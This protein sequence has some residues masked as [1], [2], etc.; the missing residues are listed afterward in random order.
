MAGTPLLLWSPPKAGQKNLGLNPLGT[1]GTEAKF[2][3]SASNIGRGGGGEGGPGGGGTPPPPP[4]YGR[5][6]TSVPPTHPPPCVGLC[7]LSV[8][9]QS[10]E[11]AE[12]WSQHRPL[13][14]GVPTGSLLLK[15]F[16]LSLLRP[17][18][19]RFLPSPRQVQL[20]GP[21]EAWGPVVPAAS[22]G[23]CSKSPLRPPVPK[24][25]SRCAIKRCLNAQ[26]LGNRQANTLALPLGRHAKNVLIHAIMKVLLSVKHPKWQHER[27]TP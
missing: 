21:S 22:G 5:S 6:N 9:A 12:Y 7:L 25:D 26:V 13:K 27:C 14:G 10:A 23:G 3:L 16:A 17:S 1:E 2:W 20:T 24:C 4:V 11:S 18:S 19:R 15:D 8:V